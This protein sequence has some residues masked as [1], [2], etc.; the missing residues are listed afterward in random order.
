MP[1]ITGGASA[2]PTQTV[3]ELYLTEGQDLWSDIKW[4][5]AEPFDSL[6]FDESGRCL[7]TLRKPAP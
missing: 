2:P 1:S 5:M 3:R 6:V 4:L 7:R